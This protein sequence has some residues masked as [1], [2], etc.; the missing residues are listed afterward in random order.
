MIFERSH[1]LPEHNVIQPPPVSKNQQSS[2]GEVVTVRRLTIL[3][4]CTVK[5][6]GTMTRGY[7][8][9]S[10]PPALPA[11]HRRERPTSKNETRQQKGESLDSAALSLV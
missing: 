11:G 6:P 9:D 2:A 4:D 1:R 5:M 10:L 3:T 8:G 7:D